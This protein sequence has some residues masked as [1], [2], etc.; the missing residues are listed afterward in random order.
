MDP[1][2]R[3]PGY[4]LRRRVLS[5]LREETHGLSLLEMGMRARGSAG[6]RL[7]G[8]KWSAADGAEGVRGALDV[9]AGRAPA[10]APERWPPA[11]Q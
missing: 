9:A 6:M 5:G 4:R 11:V 10:R 1:A 2:I 7:V 3:R 8:E